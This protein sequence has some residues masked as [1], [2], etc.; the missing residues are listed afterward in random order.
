MEISAEIQE[1]LQLAGSSARV[2]DKAFEPLLQK[3]FSDVSE[4]SSNEDGGEWTRSFNIQLQFPYVEI[5][6]G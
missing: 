5:Y 4:T 6:A 1:G 2:Q 3:I